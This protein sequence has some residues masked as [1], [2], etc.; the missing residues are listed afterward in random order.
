[1]ILRFLS[2]S[3]TCSTQSSS[4]VSAV[5]KEAEKAVKLCR[6]GKGPFF[7]E[8]LTYRMRGHVGPSDNIQGTQTDIRPK[9]EVEEWKAKD[10]IKKIEK[11]LLEDKILTEKELEEIKQE[12]KKEVADAHKF[13]NED[14]RPCSETLNE[15]VFK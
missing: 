13:A 15:Y 12:I 1:M 5:F 7:I 3:T 9:M 8:C 2:K 10:P 14:V 4:D 11:I 6:E